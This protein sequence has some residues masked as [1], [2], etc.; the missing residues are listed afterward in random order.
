MGK[1]NPLND[2]DL[3]DFI[4]LEKKR[5]S[6][7]NSWSVDI[8]NINKD[9]LD[10]GVQNPNIIEVIDERTPEQ[11]ISEIEELDNKSSEAIKKIKGLVK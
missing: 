4:N 10:I 3:V 6:S 2:N 8:D 1:T 7:E 11:I 9:T 5:N